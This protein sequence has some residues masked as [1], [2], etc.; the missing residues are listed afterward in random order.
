VEHDRIVEVQPAGIAQLHDR[1][2]RERLRDRCDPIKGRC[3]RRPTVGHIREPDVSGPD[4]VVA[5]DDADRRSG[6]S[7]VLDEPRRLRVELVRDARDR[8]A[9]GA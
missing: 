3:V 9:H 7:L 8:I 6:Q 1:D 5:V 2:A 4:E